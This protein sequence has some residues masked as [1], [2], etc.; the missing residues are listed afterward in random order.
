M[1]IKKKCINGTTRW[2]W[3]SVEN[4]DVDPVDKKV[5]KNLI[6]N[7]K[8]KKLDRKEKLIWV[9]SQDGRYSVKNRYRA[10]THSQ[11]WEEI[12]IPLN[13]CW[14]FSCLPKARFFYG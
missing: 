13:L 6:R 11:E 8:I 10:I 9:A 4:I 3:K 7:R 2:E 14:D 12:D 5:F 1:I